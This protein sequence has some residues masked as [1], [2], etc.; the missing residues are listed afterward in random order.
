MTKHNQSAYCC[1]RLKNLLNQR[2]HIQAICHQFTGAIPVATE[3]NVVNKTN[4][5]TITKGLSD[6]CGRFSYQLLQ[7]ISSIASDK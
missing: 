1:L 7:F 4:D 5:N 2:R 3:M 6:D